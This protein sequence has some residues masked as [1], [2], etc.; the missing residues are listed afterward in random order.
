M[1]KPLIQLCIALLLCSSLYAQETVADSIP[2]NK[3][4]IEKEVD[5]F[6]KLYD[7]LQKPKSYFLAAVGIGNT[8]FSVRNISLNVQQTTTNL[9]ITPT[10]G[11]Y[12]KSGLSLTYNNYF[13]REAKSVKLLQ[14][15]LTL[16]Y[17]ATENTNVGFGFSYTRFI[18]KKEFVNTS[19]PY[20]NDL[21]A[22]VYKKKGFFQPGLMAGFSAGR[23]RETSRYLDSQ[24]V[25]YPGPGYLYFFVNDTSTIRVKDFSLIPYLQF[26]FE[27]KGVSKKDIIVFKPSLMLI[28]AVNQFTIDSKG[29]RSIVERPR[30]GRNYSE[31]ASQSS[32]FN[33][34]SI[35]LNLEAAWYI[36]K[37]YINPQIYFDYY[38][39]SSENKFNTLYTVQT[40]IMF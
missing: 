1:L 32:G 5:A 9:S 15:S 7:S 6:L 17:D 29:R 34:Q 21:L 36:G 4:S 2:I 38:L 14:H 35:G 37:F 12:H 40:G 31:S 18:G 26:E 33:L 3:D 16:A 20:D 30:L 24:R 27:W 11:Y 13:L 8:Q 19:S 39:L 25:I 22:Y 28:N 23:Y 10:I